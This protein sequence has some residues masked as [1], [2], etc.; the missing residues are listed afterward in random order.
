MRTA[1][2]GPSSALSAPLCALPLTSLSSLTPPTTTTCRDED[3]DKLII[4]LQH[5]LG[6]KWADIAQEVVGRTDN[7]IK[8]RWNSTLFRILKKAAKEC[9][10]TGAAPPASI[11]DKVAVVRAQLAIENGGGGGESRKAAKRKRKSSG[12]RGGGGGGGAGGG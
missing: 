2:Q 12:G 8:N 9:E 10:R 11:E 3:E 1:A 6:N 7:A 4:S 5:K